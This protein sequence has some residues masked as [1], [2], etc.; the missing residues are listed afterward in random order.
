MKRSTDHSLT[1]LD[2]VQRRKAALAEEIALHQSRPEQLRR[3]EE[4]RRNTLPPFDLLDD[5]GRGKVFDDKVAMGQVK[6]ARRDFARSSCMTLL[7][8]VAAAVVLWW[9]YQAM[10]RYGLL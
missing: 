2:E 1:D 4:E 10:V 3:E 6:N 5:V 8:L 7:L 9:A